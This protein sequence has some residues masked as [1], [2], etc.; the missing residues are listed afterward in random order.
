MFLA[1]RA[2]IM[3]MKRYLAV[4]LTLTLGGLTGR[5]VDAA[6]GKEN[7]DL[8]ARI[9]FVGA[10]QIASAPN[11]AKWNEIRALPESA[12][13]WRDV[14]QKLGT[15]PFRMMN[16][17]SPPRK[18]DEAALISPLMEDILMSESYL[19][20]GGAS[21][22]WPEVALAVKLN[23]ARAKVWQNNLAKVLKDW[24]DISV[25]DIQ[26]AGFRG[27]ELKKHHDPNLFR[28][29]LAG[30]WVV[31]G[32]GQDQ[33]KLH[34]AILEKIKA[35]KRPVAE[36]EK[37]WLDAWIN[38]PEFEAYH[39]TALP[40]KLPKM[41]LDVEGRGEFVR[42]EL[43]LE[44]ADPLGLK[45]EPWRIPTN[46]I[47]SPLA[48]LTLMRGFGPLLS[49]IPIISNLNAEPFPNQIAIWALPQI[50]FMTCAALPVND[51][52]NYL[53]R[54]APGLISLVNSNIAAHQGIGKAQLTTNMSV[55]LGELPF[56]TPYLRATNGD[57]G[58]FLL[59]GILAMPPRAQPFPWDSLFEVIAPTNVVYY[60]RELNGERLYQWRSLS[61][62][63]PLSMKRTLPRLDTPVQRWLATIKTNL[64]D[65]RTV[66]TLTAPNELTVVR[67]APIGLTGVELTYLAFWVDGPEFPFPGEPA[68]AAAN[69]TGNAKPEQK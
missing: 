61:E 38:W 7:G 64:A 18:N 16:R 9:H 27:W 57:D 47:G 63:Y 2:T 69:R 13:V 10:A 44:F 67:N 17:N 36:A 40:F 23:S 6:A 35:N 58:D 24:T 42:P 1:E 46:M 12:E 19:E 41:E 30:D 4:M 53:M 45:L 25:Q 65:C 26:V 5:A 14:I 3:H 55:L 62:I 22:A 15:A 8:I 50:P 31:F 32:W 51:A 60:D 66:G 43:K 68:K 34:T 33:L 52:K 20:A 37:R 56:I 29:V 28:F 54:I 39:P 48:S 11:A 59:A 49:A 21:N